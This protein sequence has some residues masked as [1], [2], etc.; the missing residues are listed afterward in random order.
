MPQLN[1]IYYYN[2]ITWFFITF[3]PIYI[4]YKQYLLLYINDWSNIINKIK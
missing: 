3:I 1:N 4:L 2:L